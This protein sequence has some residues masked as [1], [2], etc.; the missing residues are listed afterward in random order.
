MRHIIYGDKQCFG[1]KLFPVVGPQALIS[2]ELQRALT[3]SLGALIRC[4]DVPL[5]T[6]TPMNGTKERNRLVGWR[7]FRKS[8]LVYFISTVG[9]CDRCVELKYSEP[10][11]AREHSPYCI[12][13]D[14]HGYLIRTSFPQKKNVLQ[15]DSSIKFRTCSSINPTHSSSYQLS[16]TTPRPIRVLGRRLQHRG[17]IAP[18][19]SVDVLFVL[20][21]VVPASIHRAKNTLEVTAGF[22]RALTARI[23]LS[24]MNNR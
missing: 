5:Y 14:C 17:D 21:I 8:G 20:Y 12:V 15:Q 6:E 10:R 24:H 13:L 7:P 19:M 16:T 2:I 4:A 18:M 23:L 3:V 11:R 1:T 22:P 9:S